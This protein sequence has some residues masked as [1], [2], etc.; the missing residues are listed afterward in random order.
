LLTLAADGAGAPS[1]VVAEV[2]QGALPSLTSD[3]VTRIR[4]SPLDERAIARLCA[5]MLGDA[6]AGFARAVQRASGGN[7]RLAVEIVRAASAGGAAPT[8]NDVGSL[9]GH[10]LTALVAAALA[11]LPAPARRLAHAL[12]VSGRAATVV[13]LGALFD[14]DAA[15]GWAAALDARAAGVVDFDERSGRLRFFSTAHA[16]AAYAALSPRRRL[17][18]HRRALARTPPEAVVDRARHLVAIRAPEASDAATLAGE[19]LI[20]RGRLRAAI[21]MLED[22]EELG[23]GLVRLRAALRLGEART[24]AGDYTGA[25]A[26]LAPVEA[27]RDEAQLRVDAMLA[28][29]RALQRAGDLDGAESRLRAV[30]S[31]R[32]RA[33]AATP[34]DVAG[35][36]VRVAEL[37]RAVDGAGQRRH[38]GRGALG[39]F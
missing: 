22:A 24:L 4:L 13:E 11:R 9:D 8:A 39:A 25:L 21:A 30:G 23:A 7:P 29:A 16:E 17:A 35:E 3:G 20:E 34:G 2:E 37:A 32:G 18:L 12:A 15:I 27:A 14:D 19:Q 6:D 33:I 10:D 36:Q 28:A 5:S 1:T 26:A 31:D 38:V